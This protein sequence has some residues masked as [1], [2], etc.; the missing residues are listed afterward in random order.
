MDWRVSKI[1]LRVQRIR[2]QREISVMAV[3][4]RKIGSDF[5]ILGVNAV[6]VH[7]GV[8]FVCFCFVEDCGGWR[9]R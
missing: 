7:D 4:S 1:E 2:I 3:Y 8:I 5:F 9:R 6:R